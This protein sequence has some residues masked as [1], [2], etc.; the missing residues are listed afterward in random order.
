[1]D[2]NKKILTRFQIGYKKI[3]KLDL[4]KM[5]EQYLEDTTVDYN[6]FKLTK[7]QSYNPI[8]NRFFQMDNDNYNMITLNGRLLA[9]EL[10]TVYSEN[11]KMEDKKIIRI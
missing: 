11:G 9:H 5:E 10:K 1:M 3:K 4:S 6:P 2:K 7:W 8:Y